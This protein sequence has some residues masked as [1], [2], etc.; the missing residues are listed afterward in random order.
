MDKDKLLELTRQIID[1]KREKK[2]FNDEINSRIKELDA[3]IKE[4]VRRDHT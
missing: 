2:N 1:L 4:L 3:E